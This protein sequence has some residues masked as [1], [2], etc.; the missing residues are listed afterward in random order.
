MSKR[1]AERAIQD[2]IDAVVRRLNGFGLQLT[3]AEK[4]VV[5][6]TARRDAILAHRDALKRHWEL[7]TES[8]RAL[9]G[10]E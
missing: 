10:G 7:L 1:T 4:A 2:E 5:A 9:R 3:R 8:L 6:A